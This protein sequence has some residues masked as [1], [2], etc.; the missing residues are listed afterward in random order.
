MELSSLHDAGG[1]SPVRIHE[2]RDL[3][4]AL[5]ERHIPQNLAAGFADRFYVH[6]SNCNESSLGHVLLCRPDIA[7]PIVQS[8]EESLRLCG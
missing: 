4:P 1:R 5:R 8:T 6:G 3:A 7:D 2:F